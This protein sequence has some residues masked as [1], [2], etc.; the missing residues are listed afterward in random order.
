MLRELHTDD[1]LASMGLDVETSSTE[2]P[3]QPGATDSVQ[4]ANPD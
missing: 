4:S 1:D 2:T 3:E